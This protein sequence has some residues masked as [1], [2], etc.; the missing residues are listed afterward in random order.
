MI[1]LLMV[2]PK[3]AERETESKQR[4]KKGRDQTTKCPS[5]PQLLVVGRSALGTGRRPLV[6]LVVLRAFAWVGGEWRGLS[7][8]GLYASSF[9]EFVLLSGKRGERRGQKLA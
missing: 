5:V 2:D 7:G 9:A 6:S 1:A 8:G 4:R 3:S